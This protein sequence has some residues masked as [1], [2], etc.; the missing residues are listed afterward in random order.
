MTERAAVAYCRPNPDN[1]VDTPRLPGLSDVEQLLYETLAGR[2]PVTRADVDDIAAG[3][4]WSADRTRA[5]LDRLCALTLVDM[6]PEQ[7]CRFAAAPPHAALDALLG[8]HSRALARTRRYLRTL[9]GRFP[10]QGRDG[11]DPLVEVVRGHTAMAERLARFSAEIRHDLLGF[12]AP[13]YFG[14]PAHGNIPMR[15]DMT[16][17]FVYDRRA[18]AA[19]RT[20]ADIAEARGPEYQ[21]RVSDLPVKFFVADGEV[22]VLLLDHVT[23]PPEAMLVVREPQLLTTLCAL[24][25]IYWEHAVPVEI[26]DGQPQEHPVALP[27]SERELLSLLVAGYTDLTIAALLGWTPRTVQRRVRGM[28]SRLG[29]E[30][31]FQAG[32][33]AVTHG[34]LTVRSRPE[35]GG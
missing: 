16:R 19:P 2:P 25:E 8:T 23:F 15:A 18:F 12:D 14:D 22:A 34:W 31:R 35:L 9:A 5:A 6:L 21:I 4:G 26:V 1:G 24:F 20:R 10:S 17:R 32:Y 3:H 7:P 30:N 33:L 27:E 28:L 11:G 29:A 13:P